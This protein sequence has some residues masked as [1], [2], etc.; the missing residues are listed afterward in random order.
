MKKWFLPLILLFLFET[1]NAQ[2]GITVAPT[3]SLSP[4]WKVLVEQFVTERRSN[5]I[6]YGATGLIDFR[7][8][9]KEHRWSLQPA[10][11]GFS[12]AFNYLDFHFDLYSIGI[13]P[14]LN[15]EFSNKKEGRKILRSFLQ[16]SPGF[17][18][19]HHRFDRPIEIN[20]QFSGQ[21]DRFT[22]HSWAFNIGL[23]FLVDIKLSPLMTVSPSI[24]YRYFPRVKWTGLT[25]QVTDGSIPNGLDNS[26]LRQMTF[27]LRLGLD[28]KN[29]KRR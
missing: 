23:N 10:V 2:L 20:G 12:T 19:F 5:F 21:H 9:L 4:R 22:H 14:N 11:H 24:G 26:S 18:Y 25:Q 3:S 7:L 17:N 1:A 13:Q 16:F 27:G 8:P 6:Q 28:L 29:G 15:F